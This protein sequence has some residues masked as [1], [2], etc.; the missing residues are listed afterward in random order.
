M[1]ARGQAGV[2]AERFGARLG[3]VRLDAVETK[4][5]DEIGA[6]PEGR[7]AQLDAQAAVVRRQPGS[8]GAGLG[9]H[10]VLVTQTFNAALPPTIDGQAGLR[11]CFKVQNGENSKIVLKSAVAADI[12]ASRS[13]QYR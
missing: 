7:G 10:L 11:V 2:V 12:A 1:S 8:D 9:I 3:P 6:A 4:L 5:V 13:Q